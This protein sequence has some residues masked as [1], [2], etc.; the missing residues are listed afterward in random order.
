MAFSAL[1]TVML[2]LCMSVGICAHL[3]LRFVWTGYELFPY[4]LVLIGLENI[5]VL[6]RSVVSSSQPHLD[7]KIRVAKGLSKEGWSITKNLLTEISLS[8]IG[9]FTFVPTIQSFC[10]LVLAGILSDFFLQMTFFAPILSIDLWRME[11]LG[12]THPNVRPKAPVHRR[13]LTDITVFGSRYP[14]Y[15]V[16]PSFSGGAFEVVPKRL[17]VVFFWARWRVFQRLLI[18]FMLIWFSLVAY[19]VLVMGMLGTLLNFPADSAMLIQNET[20]GVE[21]AA[22][23]APP[24]D[25]RALAQTTERLKTSLSDSFDASNF[26]EKFHDRDSAVSAW[27]RLPPVHWKFLFD[28]YGVT[29]WDRFVTVLPP[30][31]VTATVNPQDVL[32]LRHARDVETSRDFRAGTWSSMGLDSADLSGTY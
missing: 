30:I 12:A 13:R 22:S 2:S 20:D 27:K 8:T 24:E 10:L 3:G 21:T 31:F 28:L 23:G 25:R 11:S 29:V 1:I 4:I 19:R 32:R 18:A 5:L 26:E 9:F 6:T 15:V 17:R 16:A 7:V 14:T